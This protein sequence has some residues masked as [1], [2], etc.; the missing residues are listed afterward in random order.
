MTYMRLGVVNPQ[1]SLLL[2]KP[3]LI[4]LAELRRPPTHLQQVPQSRLTGVITGENR[5]GV[6]D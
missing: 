1:Y 3:I 6:G 2:L 4:P 5:S